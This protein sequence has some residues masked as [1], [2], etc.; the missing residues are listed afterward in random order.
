MCAM[1]SRVLLTW[2]AA[3]LMPS[4][5]TCHESAAVAACIALCVV[6]AFAVVAVVVVV[7]VV[8]VAAVIHVVAVLQL[9]LPSGP[10]MR[11]LFFVFFLA[12]AVSLSPF[13][14][15]PQWL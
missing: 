13:L 4:N 9:S 11:W 8:A 15:L 10:R 5:I 3:L 2:Y 12:C 14:T 6:A 1:A 7:A